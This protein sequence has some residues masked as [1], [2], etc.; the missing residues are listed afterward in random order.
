VA[1]HDPQD[2]AGPSKVSSLSERRTAT[3]ARS[4]ASTNA[5]RAN[6]LL[7]ALSPKDFQLLEPD[8]QLVSLSPAE[9]LYDAGD[10]IQHA[11][12]PH[13]SMVSLVAMFEDG[14]SAEVAVFGR[15]G[16]FGF[17]SSLVSKVSFGRYIV[18]LPGT[19]S[20]ITVGPLRQAA[21]ARPDMRRLLQRY[22]E[23]LLAQTFQT[24]ACNAVHS[25]EARCC[26]WILATHDRANRDD[27]PLT[28]EF[29]AQMLGVQRPTVSLVTRKHQAAG[30]IKQGR[31]VIHVVD[32]AGLEQCACDCY[33]TI[34]QS[35]ERLLPGT[36][37]H[38]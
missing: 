2:R 31:G 5:H 8:L 7:A 30:F 38:S 17:V 18:H 20:R 33:R 32:R 9:V 24:V 26:R 13:D 27:L 37:Q 3:P 15:E 6:R 29:L 4:V 23:A 19:A 22:T 10:T 12:F 11:Y 16:V 25:V 36:F 1:S 34:R 35:F 21:D 14:L 28:H